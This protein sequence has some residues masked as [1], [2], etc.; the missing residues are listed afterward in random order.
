MAIAAV[1]HQC[2][3]V[4]CHRE[5]RRKLQAVLQQFD[6]LLVAA[7]PRSEFGQ[8]AQCGHVRRE[9]AQ[10]VSQHGLGLG[11]A[12][13]RQCLAGCQQ[14]RI[15]HAG[16]R[17][18]Q[19]GTRRTRTTPSCI[20]HCGQVQPDTRQGRLQ[21]GGLLDGGDCLKLLAAFGMRYPEFHPHARRS[22]LLERK[23]EQHLQGAGELLQYV[24]RHAQ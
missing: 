21:A 18:H 14:L 9:R 8:H 22:G 2:V 1:E 7:D 6:G 23:G 20:E 24:V 12:T 19:I 11:Q 3:V 15:V 4:A 13:A 17:M 16:T 5:T 10:P